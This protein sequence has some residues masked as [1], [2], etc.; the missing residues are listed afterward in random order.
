MADPTTDVITIKSRAVMAAANL[1]P[2][3]FDITQIFSIIMSIFQGLAACAPPAPTPIPTPPVP[4]P[5]GAP[6]AAQVHQ[7][8]ANP[9]IIQRLDLRETTRKYVKNPA[10]VRHVM[11]GVLTVGGTSTID[12]TNAM[13]LQAVGYPPA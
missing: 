7:S 13:F 1:N 9:G 3:V 2:H 4:P 11:Q 6:T 8:I 10:L 5:A 12:E